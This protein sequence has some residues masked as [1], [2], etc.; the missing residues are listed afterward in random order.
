MSC[1]PMLFG[2]PEPFRKP[3]VTEIREPGDRG[4]ASREGQAGTGKR[5]PLVS[6]LTLRSPRRFKQ[7]RDDSMQVI[8]TDP[9]FLRQA[10]DGDPACL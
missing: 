1:A 9:N 7:E 2:A 8:D 6:G 5:F 3:A 4:A 10:A